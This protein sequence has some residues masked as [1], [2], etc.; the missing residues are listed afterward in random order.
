MRW[1]HWLNC[2]LVSVSLVPALLAL[3]WYLSKTDEVQS[4]AQDIYIS[5]SNKYGALGLAGYPGLEALL[6]I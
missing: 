4:F 3:K 6:L 5:A 2:V 1:S